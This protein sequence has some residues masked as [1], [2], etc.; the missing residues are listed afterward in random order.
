MYDELKNTNFAEEI[1]ILKVPIYFFVGKHD[2]I[3]P[4]ILVE[5]FYNNLEAEK[6][7]KLIFFQNSAHFLIKEEKEKYQDL[8]IK[9]VLKEIRDA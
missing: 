3:T 2:M 7:K 1:Q 4:T 6:G 5:D 9:I 8:L